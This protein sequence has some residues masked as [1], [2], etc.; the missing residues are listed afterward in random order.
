MTL[1]YLALTLVVFG[2]GGVSIYQSFKKEVAQE[3][4]FALRYTFRNLEKAI[5]AGHSIASLQNDKIIIR[6]L[7][8]NAS[9][10]TTLRF[11]DTI[12]MHAQLH[13]PE[14]HRKLTTRRFY[15][16][17]VYEVD[18]LDVFIEEEDVLDGVFNAVSKLFVSLAL[19]IIFFS[20]LLS[21]RMFKP[22]QDILNTIN[23]FTLKSKTPLKLPDSNTK[24]FKELAFFIEKMANKARHDYQAL[25]EFSENA[26]HEL[27]TP[28]SIAKGK[29][30]ILQDVPGLRPEHLRLIQS[31]QGALSRL[32]KMGKALALLTKIENQEFSDHRAV[33]F[34]AI[35][36]KNINDLREIAAL[37]DLSI[38]TRI[39]P[40]VY[41]EIDDS[42]ADI[43]VGNLLKNA[44]Q[45][46]I[47]GGKVEVVLTQNQLRISNTGTPPAVPTDRLFERFRKNNQSS[48]SLGLG[49]SIVRKI[50]E[51]CHFNIDY[52]YENERHILTVQFPPK[53]APAKV[54]PPELK[55]A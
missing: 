39:S 28:I 46:N 24:E 47:Q 8:P 22:F 1:L 53:G 31:A 9:I 51:T 7:G 45:H 49:L 17:Q 32:S 19:V 25:K 38:E 40:E 14:K 5:L 55:E 27:Q 6:P 3:T 30:E 48:A 34:S 44:I 29:L 50:G 41:V 42:L 52:T 33:N 13:R 4:D 2:F 21:R 16:D 20:F 11:S 35:L 12:A 15:K 10:D 26:S 43:L 54:R 36:T 18:V 23:R 37:K